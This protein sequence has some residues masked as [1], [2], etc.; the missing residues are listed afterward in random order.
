MAGL[1]SGLV[2]QQWYPLTTGPCRWAVLHWSFG[3]RC[4]NPLGTKRGCLFRGPTGVA[5]T[6]R[7]LLPAETWS[8]ESGPRRRIGRDSGASEHREGLGTCIDF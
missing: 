2:T 6:M 7:D 4:A 8:V 3:A 1:C 5:Q